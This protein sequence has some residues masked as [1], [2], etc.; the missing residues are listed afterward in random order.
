[1]LLQE[2]HQLLFC[3]VAGIEP[4]FSDDIKSI[5]PDPLGSIMVAESVGRL[6]LRTVITVVVVRH[7]KRFV[8]LSQSGRSY[9]FSEQQISLNIG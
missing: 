5:Q 4:D 9:R 6:N 8:N 7:V 3:C 2:A 1:M